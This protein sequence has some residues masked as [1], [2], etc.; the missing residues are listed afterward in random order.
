MGS[1][2]WDNTIKVWNVATGEMEQTLNGHT[3]SVNSV[4]FND[5]GTKVVSGSSDNTMQVW[6]VATVEMEQ[7]LNGHTADVCSDAFNDDGTTVVSC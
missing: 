2:S 3:S 7:T 5:D 4:A 6:D 1:S